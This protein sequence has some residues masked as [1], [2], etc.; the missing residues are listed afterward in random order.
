M[1]G[2][3]RQ[4]IHAEQL[5]GGTPARLSPRYSPNRK[6]SPKIINGCAECT[7]YEAAYD[8]AANEREQHGRFHAVNR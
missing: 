7:D 6:Q 1:F 2:A 3:I 4:D 5:G 8:A